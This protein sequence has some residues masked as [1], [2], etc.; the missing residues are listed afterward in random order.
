MDY[1]LLQISPPSPITSSQATWLLKDAYWL[2]GRIV[3]SVTRKI[4]HGYH[5]IASGKPAMN[6][7]LLHYRS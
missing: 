3:H 2:F 7:K 6:G 4:N 5:C 1:W